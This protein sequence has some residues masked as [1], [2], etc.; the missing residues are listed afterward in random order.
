MGMLNREID[1]SAKKGVVFPNQV[2]TM[3]KPGKEVN[4]DV[5]VFKVPLTMNKIQIKDYLEEIY[6]VPVVRVNTAI[7]LG[8]TRKNKLGF[9]YKRPDYKKA[10]VKI[11]GS[12][13]FPELKGIEG[14][15]E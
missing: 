14:I 2:F 7:Y 12:F 5:V 9:Y 8:K 6:R 1:T 10:F 3:I 4:K 13:E 11:E 15:K